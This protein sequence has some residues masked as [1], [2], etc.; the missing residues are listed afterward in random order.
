MY[1]IK[2][3]KIE[4]ILYIREIHQFHYFIIQKNSENNIT[5]L[6]GFEFEPCQ[7]MVKIMSNR[8]PLSRLY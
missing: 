6:P 2:Y 3:K 5:G 1:I 8:E 7:K 4:C